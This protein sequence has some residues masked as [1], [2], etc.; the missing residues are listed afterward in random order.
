MKKSQLYG[1]I[2]IYILSV[3]LI[4]FILIYGYNSILNF[5]NRAERVSCLKFQND[6]RNSIEVV[7]SD[8]GSVKRKDLQLCAGY[9]KV[10]LV[11]TFNGIDK[12]NPPTDDPVIR[13]DISSE[14]GKNVFL[15]DKIAKYSF[16]AGNISVTPDVMCIKAPNNKVSLR[17]EG[18]G[19]HVDISEWA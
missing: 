13:D 11:E 6:L 15:L 7:L 9:T 17:L 19:D 16:Y 18:K 8:F 2:F 5:K 12:N 1:Q 4:S 3:V 10:C 14:T